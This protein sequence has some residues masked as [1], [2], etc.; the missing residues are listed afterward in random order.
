MLAAG[1]VDELGMD[2]APVVLGSGKRYF[3]PV[4]AQHLC[5]PAGRADDVLGDGAALALFRCVF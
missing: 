4:D 3:G 2:V 5:R 1:F